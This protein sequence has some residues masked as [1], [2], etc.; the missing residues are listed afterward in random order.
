MKMENT[1]SAAAAGIVTE[2]FVKEGELVSASKLLL[3]LTEKTSS[4]AD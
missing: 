1:V 4:H 3:S 2:I